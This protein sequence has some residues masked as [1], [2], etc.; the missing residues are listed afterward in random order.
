MQRGSHLDRPLFSFSIPRAG[1]GGALE[2]EGKLSIGAIDRNA[3]T[4]S[5]RYTSVESDQR[6]RHL[7]A[8]RGAL[9]G[10]ESVMIL[11]TV[12]PFILLPIALA[13]SLFYHLSLGTERLG[14]SLVARYPCARPPTFR[15]RIGRSSIVLHS[16]SVRLGTGADGWCTT[17]IIGAEQEEVTL[18]RPF[19]ENA[20][21]VID[22]RGRV[23]FSKL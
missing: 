9:N 20:Y 19:F 12:V 5:L 15:V 7:W 13:R 8:V 17:S 6:F 1:I 23:G 14:S 18:G 3:Y 11:D 21:T 4:A 2:T 22:L 16:S 10:H